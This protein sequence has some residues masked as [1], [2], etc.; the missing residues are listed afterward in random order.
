MFSNF[1][2]AFIK[3]PQFTIQPPAAVLDVLSKDLPEGFRYINDHDGFCRIDCDGVM[4]FGELRLQIPED[5]QPLFAELERVSMKDI[6][7]Y[8]Q[9]S[10]TNIEVLPDV[11]GYYTVNDK[12]IKADKFV[13]APLNGYQLKNGRLYIMAPP[14]PDPFPIEVTGNGF[15]LN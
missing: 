6:L 4:D 10:Q 8:A 14:F 9:N 15:P 13:I 7:A 11:E 1:K 5:A 3:K 2:N 12:K